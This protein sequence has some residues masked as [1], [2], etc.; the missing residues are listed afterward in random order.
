MSSSSSLKQRRRMFFLTCKNGMPSSSPTKAKI[1]VVSFSKHS[2]TLSQ[3]G[4]QLHVSSP[5]LVVKAG[6]GDKRT[7]L[8]IVVPFRTTKYK[9]LLVGEEQENT[10]PASFI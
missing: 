8:D 3:S 5:N 7:L 1:F 9:V 4:R 2:P 6:A 10:R